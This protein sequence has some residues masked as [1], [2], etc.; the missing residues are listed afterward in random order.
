M[1]Q[2]QRIY[3]KDLCLLTLIVSL[4]IQYILSGPSNVVT[5][6][7]KYRVIAHFETVIGHALGAIWPTVP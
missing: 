5:P 6:S 1:E 4:F 7:D 3:H 2:D